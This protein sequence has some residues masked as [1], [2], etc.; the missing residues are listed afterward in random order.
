M[1]QIWISFEDDYPSWSDVIIDKITNDNIDESVKNIINAIEWCCNKKVKA[2]K[3]L[4]SD[5]LDPV[6]QVVK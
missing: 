5:K 2:L 3:I 6:Y 1:N 4:S